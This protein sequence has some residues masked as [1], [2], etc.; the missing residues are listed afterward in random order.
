MSRH[1]VDSWGSMQLYR[2]RDF[3]AAAQTG[4][5]VVVVFDKRLAEENGGEPWMRR[6]AGL[7]AVQSGMDAAL[8]QSIRFEV[9]EL[10]AFYPERPNP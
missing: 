5:E 4:D 7:A 10:L 3:F 2:L 9:A 6:V 8:Q 1:E